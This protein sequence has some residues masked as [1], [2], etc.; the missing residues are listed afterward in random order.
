VF[1]RSCLNDKLS[2]V[3]VPAFS[4][5]RFSCRPP[6]S[7][8]HGS[9]TVS[10]SSVLTC[11]VRSVRPQIEPQNGLPLGSGGTRKEGETEVVTSGR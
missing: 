4:L 7:P 10:D 1:N 11:C 2:G 8:S 5:R 6:A 9:D 3:F